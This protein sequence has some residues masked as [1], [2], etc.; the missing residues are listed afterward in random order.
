VVSDLP[1][2]SI[3][4]D[5]PQNS[6]HQWLVPRDVGTNA[7]PP[8]FPQLPATTFAAR[9]ATLDQSSHDLLTNVV[10]LLPLPEIFPLL[11]RHPI[12]TRVGDGG[13]KTCRGSFGAVAAIATIR[14]LT[15]AGPVAGPD[16]RSYRSEGYAMAA[17]V[18]AITIL[19]DTLSLP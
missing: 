14:I 15:V 3:P 7:L 10:I 17:I 13:A 16:P 8:P 2:D 9:K 12:L 6:P 18:L 11:R 5:P 1:L 4:I 19:L